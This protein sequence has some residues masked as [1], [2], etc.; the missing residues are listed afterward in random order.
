MQGVQL[1]EFIERDLTAVRVTKEVA[2]PAAVGS[3]DYFERKQFPAKAADILLTILHRCFVSPTVFIAGS[4]RK[5]VGRSRSA[6]G[7]RVL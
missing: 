7:T 2:L 4:L 3:P 5:V 6:P 1:G